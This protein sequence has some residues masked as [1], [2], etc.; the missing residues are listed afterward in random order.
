MRNYII[1]NIKLKDGQPLIIR[2]GLRRD[3]DAIWNIFNVVVSERRFIPVF[4][5]VKSEFEKQSWYLRMREQQN[6][7]LVAEIDNKVVG[8]LTI[9]HLDWDASSHVGELGIIILPKYRFM[10]IGSELI[11]N[12][13]EIVK[14][15]NLFKKICL[16]CFHNN[17][18][19]LN[20]YKKF[21][22]KQIGKREKQ[23]YINGEWIDEILFEKILDTQLFTN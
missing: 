14:K 21:G 10:G 2:R 6:L 8:E 15:E 18:V 17:Y 23:Y 19:A 12:C 20:I 16:S 22:F 9:E 11:K 13:L 7:I 4:N 3:L 5:T 1:T